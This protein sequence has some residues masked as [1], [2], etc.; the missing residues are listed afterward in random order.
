MVGQNNPNGLTDTLNRALRSLITAGGADP[1]DDVVPEFKD[2][3]FKFANLQSGSDLGAKITACIAALSSGERGIIDATRI[4]GSQ[5]VSAK[6]IVDKPCRIYL[7]NADITANLGMFQITADNVEIIGDGNRSTYIN[8][9]ASWDGNNHFNIEA[10][11]VYGLVI[12]DLGL[13]NVMSGSALHPA[14][15]SMCVFIHDN[16]AHTIGA[17]DILVENIRFSSSGSEPASDQRHLGIF[18]WTQTSAPPR[19]C[20]N[21]RI[22]KN[23]GVDCMGR[24]IELALCTDSVISDNILNGVGKTSTIVGVGV[25]I[26]GCQ[27][28]AVVSNV[29]EVNNTTVPNADCFQVNGDNTSEDIVLSDNVGITNAAGGTGI[30]I[31]ALSTKVVGTGN[32]LRYTGTATTLYGLLVTTN[33]GGASSQPKQCNFVGGSIEGFGSQ[34]GIDRETGG[35]P[36]PEDIT[37]QGIQLGKRFDGAES[38]GIYFNPNS[39]DTVAQR[40]IL[41][42]C[43][44][45]SFNYHSPGSDGG[46]NAELVNTSV[47]L[48]LTD[49]HLT[50][51]V[52]AAGGNKIIT[53]PSAALFKG[54]IYNIKKIDASA[55]TVTIDGAGAQTIDGAATHVLTTQ[56]EV[57]RIQSDGANWFII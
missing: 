16:D 8:L 41:K 19:L 14:T 50:V 30:K 13:Y 35:D 1:D 54:K 46:M 42:N 27:R 37:F 10:K 32:R 23:I 4:R 7:P 6:I 38:L 22:V 47:D 18:G 24:N 49:A 31:G 34:I 21:I 9:A 52:D 5:A 39:A 40:I 29:A 43:P 2:I 56:Y 25:R 48:T 45:G 3:N 15:N 51:V 55:N 12:R 28:I 44:F 33:P 36:Y 20:K 53:L 11:G 57:V 17:E 26:I